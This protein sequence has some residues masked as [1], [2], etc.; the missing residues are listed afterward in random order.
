MKTNKLSHRALLS[1][2]CLPVLL[3]VSISCSAS[4][5]LATASSMQA[6]AV[7]NQQDADT[8]LDADPDLDLDADPDLDLDADPDLDTEQAEQKAN[9]NQPKEEKDQAA[10]D[11]ERKKYCATARKNLEL[12]RANLNDPTFT[13]EEGN[14]VRYTPAELQKM[15]KESEAAEKANCD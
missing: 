9:D 13:T 14:I 11:E 15:I 12:L 7:I 4:I 6:I 1:Y 10:I 5:Q 2:L 3:V 8:D